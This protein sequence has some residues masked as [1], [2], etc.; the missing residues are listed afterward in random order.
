M[1]PDDFL[2]AVGRSVVQH[3]GLDGRVQFN[4]GEFSSGLTQLGLM[5]IG[6]CISVD[7]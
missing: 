1:S 7:A 2:V 4:D 6:A 5:G 3:S